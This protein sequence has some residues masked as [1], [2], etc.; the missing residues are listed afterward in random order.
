[1]GRERETGK[2]N[3]GR[4]PGRRAVLLSGL[5]TLG[6]LGTRGSHAAK[7]GSF[8]E[9]TVYSKGRVPPEDYKQS[10]IV[11]LHGFLSAMPNYNYYRLDEA[12]GAEHT[13]VGFN[14]DYLDVARN[15]AEFD[16]FYEG[17]L[18]GRDVV[19]IGTS[20]GGFWAD[21]FANRIGARGLIMVNPVADPAARATKHL[22]AHYS[23]KRDKTV[24]VTEQTVA[25]Y[26]ALEPAAD[27]GIERL[28]LLCKDDDVL[29]FRE[30]ERRYGALAGT[31]TVY[32][33]E[34]GH[35]LDLARP[36]VMPV[37]RAYIEQR[38]AA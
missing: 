15:L 21:Y 12:F 1:M 22:G 38:F 36:D 30:A 10:V 9:Y 19:V 6:L 23:K 11:A 37:I 24:V 33:D 5:A 27:A 4:G 8:F 26:A 25:D 2:A 17:F 28:L 31:R 34:G 32:F 18:R 14:Y 16:A 35:S 20:L 3:A 13:V 7:Q 29:D